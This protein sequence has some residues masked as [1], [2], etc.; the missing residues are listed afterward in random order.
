MVGTDSVM[1]VVCRDDWEGG[2]REHVERLIHQVLER[3]LQ[4]MGGEYPKF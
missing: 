4:Y 2:I 1:L 3:S